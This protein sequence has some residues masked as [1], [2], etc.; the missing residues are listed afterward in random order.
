M[1]FFWNVSEII[2]HFKILFVYS[3]V[4]LFSNCIF[5]ANY[6]L[7]KIILLIQVLYN[8]ISNIL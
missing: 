7:D 2:F 8:V 3:R 1:N 6:T 5:I 4:L